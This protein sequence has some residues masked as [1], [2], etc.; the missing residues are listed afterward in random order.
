MARP[1]WLQ[2]GAKTSGA[3]GP[4]ETVAQTGPGTRTLL[5]S[6][7]R[8]SWRTI[9]LVQKT[10]GKIFEVLSLRFK[11]GVSFNGILV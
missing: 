3:S 6:H 2:I 1:N 11:I 8:L 5:G 10:N 9:L 7:A 4:T